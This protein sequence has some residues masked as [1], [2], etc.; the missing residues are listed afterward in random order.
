MRR[1]SPVAPATNGEFPVVTIPATT[2]RRILRG[3]SMRVIFEDIR[4]ESS[5]RGLDYSPDLGFTCWT[6][7]AGDYCQRNF[8]VP[9]NVRL[10]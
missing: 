2:F 9:K 7:E 10:R 8:R 3:E 6:N 1:G 4:R 5:N